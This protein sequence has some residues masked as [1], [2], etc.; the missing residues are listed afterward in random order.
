M[1]VLL[2]AGEFPPMQ[3]GL[4]A[5][6]SC[7]AEALVRQGCQVTVFVPCAAEKASSSVVEPFSLEAAATGWGWRDLHRLSKLVRRFDIVNLQYQA[8]AYGM[9]LPIHFL[10]WLCRRL[11]LPLLT[12]FHD[13]RLPYLFP[14]AGPLR[15][16]AVRWLLQGSAGVIVTNEEDLLT[17]A[18]LAPGVR[19]ELVRIGSNI[20]PAAYDAVKRQRLR[21]QWGCTEATTVICYFGF[22]NASK[23]ALDLVEAL[24]LLRSQGEDVRLVF[25]G[26]LIGASDATNAS[27]AEQV[28][29]RVDVLGLQ[30]RVTYTGFVDEEDVSAAFY[31]SDICAL[32]YRDGAS[33]RRGSLMAALAHGMP[34]VTT[35]PVLP[36][37]GLSEGNNVLLA[38]PADP[39]TLAQGLAFLAHHPEE[40]ERLSQSARSLAQSFRWD[41]IACDTLAVYQRMGELIVHRITNGALDRR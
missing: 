8:A 26:G 19:P 4:G 9:R 18:A 36:I 14:K 38:P 23:G 28:R 13:L 39:Q 6:S 41:T 35:E 17:A 27:Y 5:F 33:Y 25:I 7:L 12:T 40:R 31:A 29:A 22:L 16:A 1:R 30:E 15:Q 20:E 10:P 2:V 3:G 11:A 24:A 21:R 37:A 34:I 32:P